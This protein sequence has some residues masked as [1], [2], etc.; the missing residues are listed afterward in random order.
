MAT[1]QNK[2]LILA[3]GKEVIYFEIEDENLK[4]IRFV[5]LHN[6]FLRYVTSCLDFLIGE[7][8]S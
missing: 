1:A 8:L 5:V 6:F 7:N 3:V 2:Q 4:Q